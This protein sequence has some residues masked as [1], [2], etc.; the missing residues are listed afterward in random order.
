MAAAEKR[1]PREVRPRVFATFELLMDLTHIWRSQVPDI[2]LESFLIIV[3]VNE[4]A[5]HK[6]LVGADAR[7]DLIDHPTPP[8]DARGSISRHAIADRVGLSRETTRRKVNQLLAQGLLV[9]T[10]EGEVRPIQRL[11]S[12]LIQKAAEESLLA[13]R[14]FDQ[15]LIALG[16]EGVR[17]NGS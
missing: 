13:V 10:S 6:M 2:D 5:M 1:L 11:Y 3:V 8:D 16:C 4:A 15:R 17:P 7:L 14:R 9:E 12:R